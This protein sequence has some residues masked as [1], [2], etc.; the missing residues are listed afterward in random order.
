MGLKILKYFMNPTLLYWHWVWWHGNIDRY[1]NNW[2]SSGAGIRVLCGHFLKLNKILSGIIVLEV[3]SSFSFKSA[4]WNNSAVILLDQKYVCTCT[5]YGF[6]VYF[7]FLLPISTC[8]LVLNS[9]Y[10]NSQICEKKWTSTLYL[11]SLGS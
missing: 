5:M 9:T 4:V 11:P 3:S 6:R 2:N 8:V 10:W 7:K 1:S